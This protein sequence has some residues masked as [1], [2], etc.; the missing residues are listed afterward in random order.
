MKKSCPS[1]YTSVR[2][3]FVDQFFYSHS[4]LITNK[5]KV[6][7]IG[8][9][10]S[11]KR[12]TFNIDDICSNVTYVNIDSSTNPDIE[13]GAEKIPVP[14]ESFDIALMGELLEHVPDPKLVLSEAYRVIRPGGKIIATT[15]FI[16]PIHADPYDFGRYTNIFWEK[17]AT[18]I[19][20]KNIEIQTQGT[21]FAVTALMIQHL[22]LSQKKSWRPI[23]YPLV[24]FFMWID[25]RTSSKMLT[26]WTTGFGFIL[27][28]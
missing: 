20:F 25:K 17:I 1:I 28:K 23:Q 19:G 18:D 3:Y 9:K 24:R 26:A 14:N 22:F 6:I 12:G 7:D 5:S 15:P 16:F 27:T 13:A 21:F 4:S 2:R 10:R 8:G 11:H